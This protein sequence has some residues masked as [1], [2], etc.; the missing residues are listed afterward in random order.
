MIV[1]FGNF[2]IFEIITT[3]NVNNKFHMSIVNVKI[4]LQ[5]LLASK[6]FFKNGICVREC[7]HI[8]I[9][10]TYRNL[11]WTTQILDICY[12]N[13]KKESLVVR[14]LA[15]RTCFKEIDF[16]SLKGIKKIEWLFWAGVIRLCLRSLCLT[17][18]R[19]YS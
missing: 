19:N 9:S 11:T 12:K 14:A 16:G 4:I 1:E 18:R 13:C 2:D 3:I 17:H 6:L 10:I 7:K 5:A 15:S 8:K